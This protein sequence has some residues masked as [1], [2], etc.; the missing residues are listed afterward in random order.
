MSTYAKDWNSPVVDS[1]RD[2]GHD[3]YSKYY[4]ESFRNMNKSKDFLCIINSPSSLGMSLGQKG[5]FDD[6]T[7]KTKFRDTVS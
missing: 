1:Q 4:G 2:L 7:K 3:S 6:K 5:L